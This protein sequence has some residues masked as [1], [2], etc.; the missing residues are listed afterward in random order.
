M[1][2]NVS[3]SWCYAL[4]LV[5]HRIEFDLLVWVT[6]RHGVWRLGSGGLQAA[7]KLLYLVK[8]N[9][10]GDWT[11]PVDVEGHAASG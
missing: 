7:L 11:A 3:F 1:R 8:S 9:F 2:T 6:R 4:P 5:S 10:L